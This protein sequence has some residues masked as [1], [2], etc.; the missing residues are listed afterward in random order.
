MSS[1]KEISY[2]ISK[3]QNDY[4]K[5]MGVNCIEQLFKL[6]NLSESEEK[7]KICLKLIKNQGVWK[8]KD[9]QKNKESIY[10]E[11]MQV[12]K[13]NVKDEEEEIE[14]NKPRRSS[15]L[16][17]ILEKEKKEKEMKIIRLLLQILVWH[18][19]LKIFSFV[20][21]KNTLRKIK[22]VFYW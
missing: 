3:T 1:H 19:Y 17:H 18:L 15:R 4:N 20:L 10:N 21:A 8:C 16:R 11:E 2:L 5:Q 22:M 7:N 6:L 14:E 9:C 12:Y 13:N